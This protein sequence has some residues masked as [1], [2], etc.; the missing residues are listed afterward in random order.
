M[1]HFIYLLLLLAYPLTAEYISPTQRYLTVHPFPVILQTLENENLTPQDTTLFFTLASNEK[2][3]F[4]GYHAATSDYRLFQDFIRIIMEEILHIP[5][6]SDFH[7][8]RIP[9]DLSFDSFESI[10]DFLPVINE[11]FEDTHPHNSKHLLSLNIALYQHYDNILELSP[12]YYLRNTSSTSPV[13]WHHLRD[14]VEEAGLDPSSFTAI[15]LKAQD[16]LP[17]E[18]GI[19]IQFFDKPDY[20]ILNNNCYSARKLGAIYSTL[21]P[22]HY[23][24]TSAITAFPQLRMVIDNKYILN[25]YSSLQMHRY[26]SLTD[27]QRSLYETTLRE[28]I[29]SL[30]VDETKRD[31]LKKKLFSCWRLSLNCDKLLD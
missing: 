2:P 13:Y 22:S 30:R 26:D 6:R 8:L 9:G 10:S 14:F 25:P 12:A 3:G 24:E 23:I 21:P 28:E 31:N 15:L 16:L 1:K 17:R 18:R 7:F 29:R 11:D 4:I 27:E 20:S 19:I 5:I